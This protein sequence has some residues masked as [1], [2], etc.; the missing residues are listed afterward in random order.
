M[1]ESMKIETITMQNRQIGDVILILKPLVVEGGAVTGINNKL[2]VKT[3]PS[4]LNNK[5]S[6]CTD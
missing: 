5:A 2:I 1:A 4:N 6:S 3:T